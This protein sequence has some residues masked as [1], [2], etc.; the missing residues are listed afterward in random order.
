MKGWRMSE[1]DLPL[2]NCTLFSQPE[3]V[4]INLYILCFKCG[5]PFLSTSSSSLLSP[6]FFYVPVPSTWYESHVALKSKR[7]KPALLLELQSI[8]KLRQRF[9]GMYDSRASTEQLSTMGDPDYA[10]HQVPSS[11][12]ASYP[13]PSR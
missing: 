7:R 5:F 9:P 13:A 4:Y 3:L 11:L 8:P 10:H 2:T 12:Q 1:S 6:L